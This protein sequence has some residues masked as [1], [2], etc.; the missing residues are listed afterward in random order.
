M[1]AW[2]DTETRAMLQP[3]PP[4]KLAPPDTATFT[5]VLLAIAVP[6]RAR[7]LATI[8]RV[9][10]CSPQEAIRVLNGRA[11]IVLRAGL[12]HEDALLGQ[13]EFVCCD[14]VSVFLADDVVVCGPRD[15]LRDLYKQLLKSPEFETVSVLVESI[16]RDPAGEKFLEQFLGR[17]D[18]TF[19]GKL[20]ILR[21]K[22]RIMEHW[23]AKIGGRV[24]ILPG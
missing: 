7:L 2:L 21:K 5:L 23:A 20:Q 22:A 17:T 6:G 24:T 12:S 19:P 16:P 3:A 11:P 4:K 13:F 10:T 14:A 1:T 15:Y 18:C 8:E 9:V